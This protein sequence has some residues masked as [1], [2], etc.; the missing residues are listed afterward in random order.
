MAVLIAGPTA[1]GKSALAVELAEILGG[2]IVNAD[3]MQVYRDLRILT[4]RPGPDEETAIPHA[5][6]GY[7]D[8]AV[9]YS[10]ARWLS[11]IAPVLRSAQA[12]GATPIIVGGTGLYLSALLEGLS[13]VPPVPDAVRTHWRSVHTSEGS[14]A[15]HAI[16]SARDPV[17]AAR[18]HPSDPQRVMRALEVLEATGQSLAHWQQAKGEP[19]LAAS[20]AQRLV[21]TPERETLREAI[22]ARFEAMVGVGGVE[23][24]AA[25]A[26]RKLDPNLPV[27]KAIG[28][29]PLAAYASGTLNKTAA[30]Q[31]AVTESRQYAKRQDTWFRNRFQAWPRATTAAGGLTILRSA[32]L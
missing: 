31:Q 12:G 17:M 7:V 19:L 11:D 30:I 13:P 24:A 6:Y 3:S 16:L 8:G 9:S 21:L 22:A 32:A 27:M 14:A 28:V 18:L 23:E 10:V 1:S 4:A 29:R 15:L 20:E 25:L 5:L 26:A 2:P